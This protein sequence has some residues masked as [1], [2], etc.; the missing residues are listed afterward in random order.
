MGRFNGMPLLAGRVPIETDEH[1]LRAR[2]TAAVTRTAVGVAGIALIVRDPRALSDPTLGIVGFGIIV[3]TAIVHLAAPRVSWLGIEE[4]LSGTAGVLIIG[5]GREH[6]DILSVMW[7]VALASGVLA[8]GGRVHW[9]GRNIVLLAL[10]LPVFRH[11]SASEDYVAFAVGT[12]GLLLTSG[13]LTRELNL[14]LRQ[15]RLEAESAETLLLAGDI[16]S[17]V[18]DR[19]KRARGY[20]GLSSRRLRERAA[21]TGSTSEQ[22]ALARLIAGDGVSIAVQP[23]VDIRTDTIHAYEAL[24]RFAAPRLDGSPLHWFE[25]AGELGQRGALERVCLRQALELFATRPAGTRLSVN[26][27]APVLLDPL[28]LATFEPAHGGRPDDL[29]GL[30]FEITEET[31]VERE[32]DLHAAITPL[33]D[34]GA[35]LAVDDMGAGYSGLR[36]ITSVRPSYLKLDRSLIAGIDSDDERAALV[37]AL[38]G[39]STRVGCM[40]VAEGVENAQELERLRELGVPLVQGFHMGRPGRPWLTETTSVLR[41]PELD[42]K[43]GE[44][45]PG[46]ALHP[47]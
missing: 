24:A 8:R 5:F 40:L 23:I 10:A 26:L 1:V 47:V 38:A 36:Q 2:R 46:R 45:P 16:A 19:R 6:V 20:D 12:L 7:L 28:T 39:Y 44:P 22:D 33:R 25:L 43:T 29:D 27:S 9:L 15:A 42:T 32:M 41:D 4:S 35:R 11:G 18:V 21:A 3:L 17:R 13:R 30:I 37:G 34:R 14:Q 31:L